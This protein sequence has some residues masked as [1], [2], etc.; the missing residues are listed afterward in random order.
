MRILV[1]RSIPNRILLFQEYGWSYINTYAISL[2]RLNLPLLEILNKK[3]GAFLVDSS[4]RKLL[5][6][7]FSR[8]I[9]IWACVLNRI[10]IRYRQE[11][12][13]PLLPDQATSW[14]TNLHTPASIVSPKEHL[15]I[16][17]LIDSRVELLYQSKALVDPEGFLKLMIKPIRA[18]WVSNE[19][20]LQ[21]THRNKLQL[22]D[23]L[24]MIC[25]NPSFYLSDDS[26]SHVQW[27]S[28]HTRAG[29]S[30]TNT[31]GYYYTPGAADDQETWAR[32]LTPE[33]F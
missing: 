32:R 18:I 9:P 7:S 5:P 11:L 6:D 29:D 1:S 2:K 8:T 17:N 16:S 22:N 28:H 14:D 25:C 30:D 23:F 3:G 15:E 20:E 12:L 33:L 26:K 24:V 4:V 21:D 31:A 19:R 27:M 10:A 13:N